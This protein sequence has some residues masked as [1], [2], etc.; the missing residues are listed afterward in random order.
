MP[1][2]DSQLISNTSFKPL[3]FAG[4][5]LALAKRKDRISCEDLTEAPRWLPPGNS[6]SNTAFAIP[7]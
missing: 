7:S 2:F 6:L 5:A 3:S 1:H 4:A